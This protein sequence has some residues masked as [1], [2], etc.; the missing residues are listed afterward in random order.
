MMNDRRP[1][2]VRFLDL[3][4]RL[5]GMLSAV[6]DRERQSGFPKLRR[7]CHSRSIVAFVTLRLLSS[8]RVSRTQMSWRSSSFSLRQREEVWTAQR[9]ISEA[10][11]ERRPGTY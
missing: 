10:L 3:A 9:N 5:L 7:P 11:R 2:E 8:N 1:P 4:K 6:V